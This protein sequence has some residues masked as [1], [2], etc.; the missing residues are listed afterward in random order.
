MRDVLD[1][2]FGTT[3]GRTSVSGARWFGIAC[4]A[5]AC[6]GTSWYTRKRAERGD[7]PIL[8]VLF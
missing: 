5:G 7:G 6:I 3:D 4:A 1:P 8:G 2:V